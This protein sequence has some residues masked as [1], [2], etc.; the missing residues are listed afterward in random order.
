MC[1]YAYSQE[2]ITSEVPDT[3]NGGGGG[4]SALN[5][6][7]HRLIDGV[8]QDMWLPSSLHTSH[9]STSSFHLCRYT[10]NFYSSLNSR[11]PYYSKQQAWI[12]D[13]LQQAEEA[14]EKV[15]VYVSTVANSGTL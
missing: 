1:I 4:S 12:M 5:C 6:A 15:R 13:T 10:L 9:P 7:I 11:N 2:L 14:G 3:V 8:M